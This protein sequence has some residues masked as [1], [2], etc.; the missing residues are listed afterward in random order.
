MQPADASGGTLSVRALPVLVFS[1]FK[2]IRIMFPIKTLAEE[3]ARRSSG[4]LTSLMLSG[5]EDVSVTGFAPLEKASAEHVAFI[6]Q[7]RL[8]E[9]L[10]DSRAGVVVMREADRAAIWGDQAPDRAVVVTAD[11]YA[12]FA[13]AQQVIMGGGR[14]EGGIHPRAVIEQGASVD[15]TALIEAN[16]VI[17]RGAVVGARA[18][19]Y[20][21][22]YVGEGA[23]IGE[24]ATLH[25]NV[26]VY[27]G[28]SVGARTIIHSGAVIGADGFGFAPFAGEWV[29]IPQVGA[30]EIGED[31]EIGANT[32]IDRGAIENTVVGRGTKLDNQIQIGHN[33]RIGEHTVM[34]ACTGV[35][36]S[37]KI[38]SHCV[39]GGAARINGHIEIPDMAM[40]GPGTLIDVWKQGSR[41]QIGFWPSMEKGV[42]ERSAAIVRHLPELRRK[43]MELERRLD[44]CG[45]N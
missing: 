20:P 33:V 37:T 23:R 40:V 45:K 30:V 11:P 15:P 29:K 6:A 8:R 31:A 21:G 3:I 22:V 26:V 5:A 17:A 25:A 9:A 38:G 4:R 24:D 14:P 28:C 42:F 41:V 1:S 16:A 13:W 44:E 19:I 39:I 12:W 34:S 43:V 35:A 36:G 27:A 18:H 32:T 10:K 2:E 7:P